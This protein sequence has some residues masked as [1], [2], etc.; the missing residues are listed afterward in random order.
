MHLRRSNLTHL[1][2]KTFLLPVGF[3]RC[4]V[5]YFTKSSL[6][7][8]LKT[9]DNRSVSIFNSSL[10][11]GGGS[12]ILKSVE[13]PVAILHGCWGVL[14]HKKNQGFNLRVMYVRVL[15]EGFIAKGN[16]GKKRR[17]KLIAS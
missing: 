7:R 1:L 16:P 6:G 11:I 12:K 5:A 9:F 4:F 15:Q 10:V 14:S 3:I 8:S 2:I 17:F 13:P